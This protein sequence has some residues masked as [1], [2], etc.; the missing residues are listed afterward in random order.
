MPIER[1]IGI[2]FGTSTSVVKIKTYKDGQPLG[3]LNAVEY[4]HFDNKDS[5]PT[6]IYETSDGKHLIGYEAEN[7]AVKGILYSNFKLDL[8]HPEEAIRERA[9]AYTKLFFTYMVEAYNDQKSHFPACD[10]ETTY[11]SY[12][13]KWSSELRN[14][15]IGIAKDAG[16]KNVIGLDEPTA[17]IHTVMVLEKEK[18]DLGGQESANILMID[19][20]AGTTD[21]VL[22][23]YT[24]NSDKRLEILNTWPKDDSQ[25]LF[26]GREV[27]EALCDYVRNYLIDCG[28][29]NTKNFNEKYLDKCKT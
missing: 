14:L 5:L 29:P 25:C 13:A 19:M 18:L 16:F 23:R 4:V 15:M 2:D 3:S 7:A 8:I 11:I 17:A 28:L 6:L 20:G 24:P 21:L 10:T 26:G 27:D 9:I 12:P 1:V 22:C